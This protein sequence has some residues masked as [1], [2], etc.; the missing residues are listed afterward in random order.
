MT[1]PNPSYCGNHLTRD[2]TACPSSVECNHAA[3]LCAACE[4]FPSG[5]GHFGLYCGVCA[6]LTV[7][8]SRHDL[9]ADTLADT[10]AAA[11][12]YAELDAKAG[13]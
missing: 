5:S 10:V 13:R 11:Q 8:T 2:H 3:E 1:S 9:D 7:G 4:S 12:V 6:L